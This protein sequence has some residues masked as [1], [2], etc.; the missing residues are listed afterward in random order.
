MRAIDFEGN[1]QQYVEKWVAENEDNYESL[2]AMESAMPDLYETWLE[3]PADWLHGEKPSEYF[4]Q[5]SDA[6]AAVALI[7]EYY[8]KGMSVPDL[9]L[10]RLVDLR[11]EAALYEWFLEAYGAE[12]KLAVSL[13]T[14]LEAKRPVPDY[15]EMLLDGDEDELKIA[16]EALESLGESVKEELL[17]ALPE[18]GAEARVALT[19]LLAGMGQDE[20]I[21]EWLI[22]MFEEREDLRHL[23]AAALAKYGDPRALEVLQ[24]ALKKTEGY[25]VYTELKNAIEA[26]GGEVEGTRNFDGDADYE[27]LKGEEHGEGNH[28][29]GREE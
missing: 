18:A 27:F 8:E 20:R 25:I 14:E 2:E 23:Y 11:D 19:N 29:G 10:D 17:A 21:Y 24:E 6:R 13:M 9:L 12:R 3:T 16:A 1:F 4:A 7:R 15:I 26:L 28:P 5:L 22:R